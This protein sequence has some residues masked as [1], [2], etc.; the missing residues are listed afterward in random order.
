MRFSMS[1]KSK[2]QLFFLAVGFLFFFTGCKKGDIYLEKP[3]VSTVEKFFEL[4]TNVDV[5]VKKVAAEF[6]R[7]NQMTGFLV[8]FIKKYGY[9]Q[10]DKAV[11]SY[12]KQHA[13]S[14]TTNSF[15]EETDTIV[16]VPFLL[17]DSNLVGAFTVASVNNSTRLFLYRANDYD[18]HRY[19]DVN[20]TTL[21]AD[22]IILQLL[23]FNEAI[24]GHRKYVTTDT[25]LFNVRGGLLTSLLI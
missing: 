13:E 25:S 24:F 16:K 15:D 20:A 17:P 19:G 2:F 7:Q 14:F 12:G 22:R 6:Y 18:R 5:A 3:L 21:T 23:I 10:W 9:P 1:I 8:S 4:P 11:I